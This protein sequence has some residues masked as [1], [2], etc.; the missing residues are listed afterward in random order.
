MKQP[1][2]LGLHD[3]PRALNNLELQERVRREFRKKNLTVNE[4]LLDATL[5]LLL[6]HHIAPT[7]CAQIV[8]E[9]AD[10][11]HADPRSLGQVLQWLQDNGFSPA[12]RARVLRH[13]LQVVQL[14]ARQCDTLLQYLRRMGHRSG[15]CK[16]M[17]AVCPALLH[18]DLEVVQKRY[19]QLLRIFTR[20]DLNAIWRQTPALLLEEV[21]DVLLKVKYFYDVMGVKTRDLL[22]G[23]S[24]SYSVEH[25]ATRHELL[26]RAGL[27]EK[28]NKHG[29][30]TV[31][32]PP[33]QLILDSSKGRFCRKIGAISEVEF[34]AFVQ[35]LE[36]DDFRDTQL[37]DLR[38]DAAEDDDD[39]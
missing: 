19:D 18:A 36:L 34:D 27:Y 35:A 16:S 1:D 25:V 5:R 9:K 23:P 13:D 32:N 29:V 24:L 3:N 17:I 6:K 2:C 28:P 11:I 12:Q 38:V 30:S 15:D 26:V 22:K 31:Q 21:D 4:G 20:E 8:V 33:L 10:I 14:T 7:E 37:S 39:E